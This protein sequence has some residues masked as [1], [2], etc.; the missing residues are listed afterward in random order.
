MGGM[1]SSLPH[2][3]LPFSFTMSTATPSTLPT[4]ALTLEERQSLVSTPSLLL[5]LRRTFSRIRRRAI[6]VLNSRRVS[7]F[8][9]LLILL[10]LL[11]L[12]RSPHRPIGSSQPWLS[13][14]PSQH[15]QD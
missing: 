1:R 15:R 11:L 8:F 7:V 6:L 13:A 5:T 12:S 9:I 10:T 2:P 4:S 14:P 3:V